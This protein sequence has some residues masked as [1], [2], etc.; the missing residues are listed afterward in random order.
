M[1]LDLLTRFEK[2]YFARTAE[3]K[4]QIYRL[5]Y[6][7][8]VTELNKANP[9]NVDHT[10]KW[11]KDPEDDS[12]DSAI[13]YTKSGEEISGSLRVDT[14]R[15]GDASAQLKERFSLKLFP[16][17]P[18]VLLCEVG[19]LIISRK[20]RGLLILPALVKTSYD[21]GYQLKVKYSFQYCSPGLVN[22]YRKLGFRPYAGN[23]IFTADGVRIPM[24]FI[25]SDYEYLIKENSPL[26]SQAKTYYKNTGID[27]ISLVRTIIKQ[28]NKFVINKDVIWQQLQEKISEQ[29][30]TYSFLNN[31]S[32]EALDVI[33]NYGLIIEVPP[34]KKIF[35]DDLVEE[36][37]AVILE[38][39]FEEVK[40]D[41]QV[42]LLEKG[43]MFG[44]LSIFLDSQKRTSDVYSVTRGKVLIIR[45]KFLD[46][47]KK[48]NPQIAN[49]LL[50]S[51]CRYFANRLYAGR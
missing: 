3:E 8:Y 16:F 5:R 25:C 15:F 42:A 37:I 38:G 34:R 4:E 14:F 50:F 35:R 24:M 39:I 27:D 29:S 7:V 17:T 46:D 40:K 11:I 23:L 18:D 30:I 12:P 10:K 44:E 43:D 13:L 20:Y 45:R 26:V 49:E 47:L 32:K 31:L 41:F 1:L 36:E 22:H 33:T 28:D 6:Q 2:V 48:N 19:R 21:Y 9:T 51:F